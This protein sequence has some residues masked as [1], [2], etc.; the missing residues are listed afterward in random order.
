MKYRKKPVVIEAIQYNGKNS[1]EIAEFMGKPI[2]TK[3]SPDLNNPAGKINIETLEGDMIAIS[4]DYIIKGIEGEFYPCKPNI[5][6]K[7]YEKVENNLL[8]GQ[9]VKDDAKEM[10][11]PISGGVRTVTDHIDFVIKNQSHT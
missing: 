6:E 10:I 11:P 9:F 4:G 3:T 1:G 8:D 2:R 5:F 7:T